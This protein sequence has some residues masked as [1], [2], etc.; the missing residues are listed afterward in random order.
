M[1][2]AEAYAAFVVVS[3]MLAVVPGPAVLYIATRSA[4]QG[5]AAGMVSV[6]GI[7]TG[8]MVHMIAATAGLSVVLAKSATAMNYIRIAGALY[9]LYLGIERL[10]QGGGETD[11]APVTIRKD[12]LGKIYR[13]GVVVNI[14]NPKTS[15]FFLSFLPQF[16]DSARGEASLQILVL[17]AT[18][19]VI[20][21]VSDAA[22]ALA[23]SAV[24]SAAKR[25]R[26]FS[27]RLGAYASGAIYIGLG[28]AAALSGRKSG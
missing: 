26:V 24:A 18:F 14:L 13:D 27:K 28:A 21:F 8:G 9:L 7:A 10:R 4:T 17:G 22:Y 11:D 2:S 5:R 15:L 16:V 19:L 23:A 25:R 20:A 12:T 1:V 6:A 3:L